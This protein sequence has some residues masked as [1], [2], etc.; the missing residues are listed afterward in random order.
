MK[1]SLLLLSV[2]VVGFFLGHTIDLPKNWGLI[3]QHAPT[4]GASQPQTAEKTILYWVAPMDPNYRRDKPGK[5]P[6]GMDLIPVYAGQ[7]AE[8]KGS[9]VT[10]S[11]EVVQ[12][13]G[14]RTA[15][16]KK[17]NMERRIDTVGYVS[18]DESKITHIH[19]RTEGWVE[20]LWIKFEG[21]SVQ[22]GQLLFQYYSPGLVNA[23]EEFLQAATLKNSTMIQASRQRLLSLG[24]SEQQANTLEKTRKI[25]SLV[26]FFAPQQGIVS[27]LD[28][29]EGMYV[30]PMM[31]LMTLV[32]L[33]SVWLQTSVFERQT[34]WV[35]MGGRAEAQLAYMPGERWTGKVD[36]I[37]PILDPKTRTLK[38][39]LRFDNPNE[40]LKPNMYAKVVIFG[41]PR[42]DILT[43][44]REAIIRSG[45]GERVVLALGE[46]RF[47]SRLIQSGMESD[48]LVEILAG[49]QAG[50]TVVTSAQF[51][52]DSQANL[53]GS[54]ARMEP[55][56]TEQPNPIL[57]DAIPG[58]GLL[59][60]IMADE[61]QVKLSHDPIPA[62]NWPSMTMNFKL[63]DGVVLSDLPADSKVT[64]TLHRL[65]DSA[66]EITQITPVADAHTVYQTTG[67]VRKIIADTHSLKITHDPIP[68]LN[69]PTMTMDFALAPELSLTAIQVG[70]K[71]A[72]T[73]K[74]ISDLEYQIVAL[75]P[76][77][78]E[79]TP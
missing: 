33:Q 11:P 45:Q 53:Q 78:G 19:L 20:K 23:Q 67:M 52:I 5:S 55:P 74:K 41:T 32:D 31:D 54:L 2:L 58:T 29:R 38:V 57:P 62:L 46:G 39:R 35:A 6:M 22:E 72:F 8:A 73:L 61:R 17:Q 59:R 42:P 26:S 69:W 14:I 4:E 36:F 47:Q 7:N 51:L 49:L 24:V 56:K 60:Q 40:R 63:A 77:L 71:L 28:I 75:Q 65:K 37:Y 27:M 70:Q 12:N 30:K 76:V 3:G 9:E 66:V 16:A 43:I 34:D 10:I 18:L 44:P 64:F 21:E 1:N 48:G 79:T 13:L 50:D 25:Q 15:L 68:A